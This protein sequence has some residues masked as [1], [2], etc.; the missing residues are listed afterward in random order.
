MIQGIAHKADDPKT[1]VHLVIKR[2]DVEAPIN[3]TYTPVKVVLLPHIQ[4]L[5]P[6][7]WEWIG[8]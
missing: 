2:V 6:L 8:P 7:L 4:E 3:L 5:G 1:P